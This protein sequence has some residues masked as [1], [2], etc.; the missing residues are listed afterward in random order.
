M[1]LSERIRS[2]SEAAP[3]VVDEVK[4]IEQRLEEMEKDAKR[5]RWIRNTQNTDIRS[6]E[7]F[8]KP[9][10]VDNIFVSDGGGFA[11]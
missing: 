9:G 8:D 11:S 2:N 4:Q 5:Y 7:F 3:W 6:E 10:T 1:S